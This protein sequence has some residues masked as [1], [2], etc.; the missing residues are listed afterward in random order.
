MGEQSVRK[1]AAKWLGWRKSSRPLIWAARVR[2]APFGRTA[3]R[4]GSSSVS[5]A[6]HG[7][8]RWVD[9]PRPS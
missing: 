7:L 5:A 2:L 4:T 6:C 9:P 3:S 8:A 1:M